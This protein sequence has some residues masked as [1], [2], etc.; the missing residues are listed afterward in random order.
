V[1]KFLVNCFALI[2]FLVVSMIVWVVVVAFQEQN[3]IEPEPASVVLT[4]D[5]ERPVVEQKDPSPF[6]LSMEGEP[7]ALLDVLTAIDHATEDSHVKGIAARFGAEQPTLAQA[8]E[9]RTALAHFRATGKFTYAYGTDF[10]E[11]GLGNRVYFLASAFENIWLQPVGTVSL[12]GVSMQSPFAK[13]TLD[14]IGVVADFMQRE[15]YKSFMEIGQRDKFSPL[16]KEEMQ[17]MIDNLSDQIAQGIATSRKWDIDHVKDLMVRGPYTDEE[18]V[19]E[20]LITRLA[21]ADEFDDE[22][23]RKAG[24]DAKQVDVKDYLDY[25]KNKQNTKNQT[26]V[27]LIYGT[28]V[29][30]DKSF[31]GGNFTN[32]SIMGADTISNA[33]A[34]AAEDKNVKAIVFRVDSR[35]GSPSASETI[36]R[37]MIGAQKKGKPVI[38]SMGDTAASGGYWIAM[39]GDK[40]VANPSTLTGSIGVVSGKFAVSGLLQK[41]G[42]SMDGVSTA[43]NAGMWNMMSSF[44]PLQRARVNAL[45][46]STYRA[47]VT[48][49][50][51]ARKIPLEKMPDVA[52]GRVFTGEQALKVGLVDELGGYDVTLK[53][54]RKALK[55]EDK[56][57]IYLQTFPAPPTA[58]ERLLKWMHRFSSESAYLISAASKFAKVQGALSSLFGMGAFGDFPVAARMA[59]MEELH[60]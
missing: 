38:V 37:A 34:D 50:S 1:L 8:Q 56:A 7:M 42:V 11:F 9:I 33:F 32:E 16:V 45:L 3:R 12:T 46:D 24:T 59:P 31:E 53:A 43:G 58:A 51:A 29:V 47:F 48:N 15:E 21:Y 36:R 57:F 40:I 19:Q 10:G 13:G 26:T 54:V 49:V 18:A 23:N 2:G 22:I 55:L 44:T 20:G 25:V 52:K 60:D 4:I 14:K 17:K 27:A 35:G 41:I 6:S 30:M 5:F 28:G 39:N